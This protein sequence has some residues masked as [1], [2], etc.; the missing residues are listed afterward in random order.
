MLFFAFVQI[1]RIIE[2]WKGWQY[3]AGFVFWSKVKRMASPSIKD[4]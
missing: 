4:C 2:M 3:L 1:F